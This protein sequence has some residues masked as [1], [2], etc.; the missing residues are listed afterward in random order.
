M[1]RV[2]ALACLIIAQ[3][4]YAAD[5]G[6]DPVLANEQLADPALEARA[7]ALMETLRC[8]QCQGQSIADSDA[9]IAAAMRSEVRTRMQKGQTED[10]IRQWMISR[11][12]EWV[13]YDPPVRG[14]ALLLWLTPVLLLAAAL[15]MA[16]GLFG[17]AK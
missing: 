7:A 2:I 14:A 11:Y 16:R 6:V 13:S 17:K 15:W 4:V 10:S 5:G 9:P 8:T 3:P 1:I 12:G